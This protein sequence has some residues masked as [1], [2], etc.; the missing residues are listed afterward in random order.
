MESAPL[1]TCKYSA[2]HWVN[3]DTGETKPFNCGSWN[4][5]TCQSKIAYHYACI[6]A[7]AL[8]QRM[9][10]FTNVPKVREIASVAFSM[11][12]RDI[13]AKYALEYARFVEVGAKTG[14]LHYHLAQRGDFIPK[15]WL[16]S[17]AS[18]NGF[19]R[20]VDIEACSGR[21]PAFYLSK[22]ITKEGA[23]LDWRKVSFSRG[24]P[25]NKT[26][27]NQDKNWLLFRA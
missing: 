24:F 16:S 6:V 19:G 13:R 12:V 8:P 26:D 3:Q 10:T 27:Y 20:I 25:R 15:F 21:G 23:P 7:A 22:Y 11:L 9:I 1:N 4:C 17:R 18:A 2:W 5:P 14:M